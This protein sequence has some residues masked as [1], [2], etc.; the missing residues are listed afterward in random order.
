[1]LRISITVP[2][3]GEV[4]CVV[5]VPPSFSSQAKKVRDEVRR[6]LQEQ[7]LLEEREVSV[8]VLAQIVR[9][10]LTEGE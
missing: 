2:D 9:Q 1:M 10:L 8:A 4:E 5:K 7:N 3:G 6:V